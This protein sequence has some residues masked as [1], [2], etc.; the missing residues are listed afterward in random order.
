L[1]PIVVL[2]GALGWMGLRINMGSAMMAAV[3]LGL[4]VDASIHYL[5]AFQRALKAGRTIRR[6]LREAQ[7]TVGPATV[8]A[9]LALV[10]GFLSLT[11]SQFVPTADF[12][13]LISWTMMGGLVSNLVVLPCLLSFTGRHKVSALSGHRLSGNL[14]TN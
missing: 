4:S 10:V 2:M 11:R 6:A 12:G 7:N 1:L 14:P 3:S 8:Y 5:T 13:I 9:A